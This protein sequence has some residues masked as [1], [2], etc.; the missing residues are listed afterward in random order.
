MTCKCVTPLGD[1]ANRVVLIF[2]KVY[3]RL[4]QDKK[5]PRWRVEHA[6]HI[7]PDDI[8][9][10]NQHGIIVSMQGI[11]CTSDAPFVVKDW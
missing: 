5:R 7:Q 8:K 6:Q 9:R 3:G 11:H 2:K 4:I 10:F 1:R